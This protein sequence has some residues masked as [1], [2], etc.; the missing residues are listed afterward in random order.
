[1]IQRIQTIWLLISA[2]SS[3]FLMKGG[4]T[5]F[6]D[7][8]GQK[9][10]TGFFGINKLSDAGYEL[11]TSSIPLTILIIIIPVLSVI[12]IL[13]FQSRRVQKMLTLIL[14]LFSICLLVLVT[15]CSYIIIMHYDA[16]LI[17]G[18]KMVIPVIILSAA[19][20]AYRGISRDDRLVKSYD[21]LR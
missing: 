2:I 9:Y 13:F 5:N 20:L 16:K 10:L 7:K 19:I 21:R 8:T 4:I 3:G 14:I 1:M 17:P 12:S 18:V 6:I 11:I 15:N